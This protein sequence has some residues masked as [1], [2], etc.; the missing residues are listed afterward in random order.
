MRQTFHDQ[1]DSLTRDLQ[2]MTGM[3]AWAMSRAST[4]LL[5]ADLG[6]SD[7][8]IARDRHVD[9]VH[10]SFEERAIDLIARQQPVATDLRRLVAGL[11]ISAEIERMGDLATHIAKVARLRYPEVAIPGELHG[12]VAEMSDVAVRI[13]RKSGDVIGSGN[14]QDALQ[15]DRDDDD[16]DRLHVALFQRLLEGTWQ[17]GIESAIDVTLVGRYFERYADHAVSAARHVVYLVTGEY[18]PAHDGYRGV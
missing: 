17:H 1:L 16:M 7:S 4:A 11:R 12:T 2:E 8:V 3:V 13:C 15:I 9:E 14:V 18:A 10:H 6:L 5:T